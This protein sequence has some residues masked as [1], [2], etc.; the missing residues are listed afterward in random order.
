[1]HCASSYDI[2]VSVLL[3]GPRGVGKCTIVKAIAD[4]L[5]IHLFEVGQS[6]LSND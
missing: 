4:G 3:V 5:G 6:A 1:M 2:A